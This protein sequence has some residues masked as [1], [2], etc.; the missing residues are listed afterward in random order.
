MVVSS[1]ISSLSPSTTNTEG[2]SEEEE[3][4]LLEKVWLSSTHM[5]SMDNVSRM[6]QLLSYFTFFKT[7]DDLVFRSLT[8][9]TRTVFTSRLDPLSFF[10]RFFS[11]SSLRIVHNRY[12]QNI[13]NLTDNCRAFIQPFLQSMAMLPVIWTDDEAESECKTYF[14]LYT[15]VVF[16]AWYIT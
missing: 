4:I 9:T 8:T 16:L 3:R 10:Q 11:N 6:R 13:N 1:F 12:L 7:D 5:E 2:L 15:F 14:N